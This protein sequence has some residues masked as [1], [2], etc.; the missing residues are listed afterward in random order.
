MIKSIIRSQLR[1]P[2]TLSNE[3]LLKI[4][5]HIIEIVNSQT[6]IGQ[7]FCARDLFGGDNG[8]WRK[9]PLQILYE[10]RYKQYENH[11][12]QDKKAYNQAAIDLGNILKRILYKSAKVYEIEQVDWVN[13]YKQI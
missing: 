3:E 8:D 11:P 7:W 2:R 10:R 12:D 4:E 6:S 13:Q 9:T 5:T 1:R